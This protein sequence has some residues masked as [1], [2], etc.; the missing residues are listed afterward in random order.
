MAHIK[1]D[2]SEQEILNQVY[3]DTNGVLKTN[4]TVAADIEIGSIEIKDAVSDTR[5]KVSAINTARTTSEIGLIV[6]H[7]DAAGTV[8]GAT[9]NTLIS[10]EDQTNNLLRVNQIFSYANV[11]TSG[12][13]TV[14]SAAGFLHALTFNEPVSGVTT[15]IT[16]NTAAGGTIIGTVKIPAGSVNGVPFTLVYDTSCATGLTLSQVS[17]VATGS[18]ITVSY[19]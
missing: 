16:D 15:V 2:Y 19:R 11:T 6:Q 18:N 3:D 8:G 9:L 13:T 5:A 10:G 12:A 17:G 14:L 7:I 1:T 4:T